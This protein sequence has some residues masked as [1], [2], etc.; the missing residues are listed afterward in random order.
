VAKKPLVG[1]HVGWTRHQVPGVVGQQGCVL[2]HSAT[3][4]GVGEGGANGGDRGG[5]RRSVSRQDQPVNR[6]ENA[7]LHGESPPGGRA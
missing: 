6:A 1:D 4:V 2:L 5:I 3:P 7:G